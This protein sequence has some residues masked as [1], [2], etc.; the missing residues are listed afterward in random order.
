MI[1]STFD[2]WN[3]LIHIYLFH[4]YSPLLPTSTFYTFMSLKKKAVFQ[5]IHLFLDY[6]AI[7][8]KIL[9]DQF[10]VFKCY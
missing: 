2:S 10:A 8:L 5:F 7:F 9:Q 1:Q 3:S 6:C 4:S